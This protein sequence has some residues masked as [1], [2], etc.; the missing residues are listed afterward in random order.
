[1]RARALA[2]KRHFD[3]TDP[4]AALAAFH[5]AFPGY[6]CTS[7]LDRLRA[8][9][10][11]RLD[12]EGQVYLDYTG[13]ALYAD[14]QVWEHLDLL[15]RR[16]LGNPHSDNPTSGLATRL[17]D[18]ARTAVL[19]Y[20][21]APPDEYAVI[22][23]PNASG[24]LRLVGESYPFTDGGTLLLTADN[25]NSVN[26]IRE[27]ARV[28]GA[29]TSYAPVHAPDLRADEGRLL[30]LLDRPAAGGHRLFAYPAQSNFS[31]VQHPL[32]WIDQAHARGWDVLLDAAAFAPTNRLDVSRHSPDFVSLSFYKMIGYPT[33][34]GCLLARRD[35]LARLQRPWF[36]GGTVIAATVQGDGHFLAAGEAGFEDGTVNFLALPAVTIG[37]RHLAAIGIETVHERVGCLTG[38]LLDSLR[39]L[40][41]RG[42]EPLVRVHGPCTTDRRGGTIALNLFD[43]SG[44]PIDVRVVERRARARAI[45]LRTGCFCNPGAAEAAFGIPREALVRAFGSNEALSFD[46]LAAALGVQGGGAVRVSVGAVTNFTDVYAFLEFARSFLDGVAAERDLPERQHC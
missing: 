22:F 35:A 45:S 33:G 10:Y 9:E 2:A 36:A 32:D 26:G 12:A 8:T 18:E 24:A 25:H 27:F 44:R 20:F 30:G 41:H 16:V 14:S 19:R 46:E 39:A 4:E 17:V 37:L 34:V 23:T 7:A 40:R 15:R 21:N 29:V 28:K 3:Y 38:W 13:A 11:G 5:A 42:G 43:P 6:A 1:M 31:G